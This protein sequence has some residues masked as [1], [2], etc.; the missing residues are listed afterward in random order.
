M[1]SLPLPALTIALLAHV[2]LGQSLVQIPDG[3]QLNE[4]A[5]TVAKGATLL[6]HYESLEPEALVPEQSCERNRGIIERFFS[7]PIGEERAAL[8]APEGVKQ[9][10]AMGIQWE[11]LE[12]QR[13]N[14]EQNI[15][16]FPGWSWHDVRVWDTQDPSVFWV[17]ADGTTAPGAVPHSAGHY[18]IQAVVV[19][20]Q[21]TLL[22]EFKV[23]IVLTKN[24]RQRGRR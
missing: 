6:S 19:D 9:I 16:L 21:L 14:N 23:S 8:Y 24:P 10:P 1:K 17:E 22:R 5:N 3:V 20:E 15:T 2:A 13:S 11:G 7:L 18:L 12:A 4:D